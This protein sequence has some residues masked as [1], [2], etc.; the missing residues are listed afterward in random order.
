MSGYVSAAVAIVGTAYSISSGE[1]AAKSAKKAQ[2]QAQSNANAQ[3]KQAE[4]AT[5][6]ANRK[7]PDTMAIL[8]SAKQAGM[9]ASGT[10]LTGPGGVDPEKLKLGKTT[11]LGG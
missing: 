6:R 11:L 4:E 7:T 1:R 9:G 3:I 5:N 10:M 2:A 8:D